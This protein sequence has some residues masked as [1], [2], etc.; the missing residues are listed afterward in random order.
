MYAEHSITS[1][2]K[3]GSQLRSN[4]AMHYGNN[5]GNVSIATIVSL[6]PS[7]YLTFAYQAVNNNTI[8]VTYSYD[9]GCFLLR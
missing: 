1:I 4:G 7:D 8:L 9:I 6:T 2:Y 5:W 3:N